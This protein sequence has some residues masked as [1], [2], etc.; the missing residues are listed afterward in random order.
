MIFT[1]SPL[2]AEPCLQVITLNV[3]MRLDNYLIFAYLVMSLN[4]ALRL[5]KMNMA[6]DL[7]LNFRH[8]SHEQQSFPHMIYFRLA[9]S[10]SIMLEAIYAQRM[11]IS[12]RMRDDFQ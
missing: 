10:E 8:N 4:T 2:I 3:V 1:T 9:D 6:S 7:S 11:D 5:W 12:N